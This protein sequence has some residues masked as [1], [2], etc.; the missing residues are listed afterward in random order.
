MTD[1]FTELSLG[2]LCSIATWNSRKRR[3][4]RW[5]ESG[6]YPIHRESRRSISGLQ[7]EFLYRS[8]SRS[9]SRPK[10]NSTVSTR[11]TCRRCNGILPSSADCPRS[12]SRGAIT[13]TS[14]L[15]ANDPKLSGTNWREAR[16]CEPTGLR[17][18]SFRRSI[19]LSC[20]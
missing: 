16:L 6:T 18:G 1:G 4:G 14:K 2:T 5:N 12:Q 8:N 19:G 10:A 9:D 15:Y 11:E 13:P 3:A 17:A 7:T 20:R